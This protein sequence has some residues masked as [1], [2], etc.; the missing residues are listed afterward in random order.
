MTSSPFFVSHTLTSLYLEGFAKHYFT[1]VYLV[2]TGIKVTFSPEIS[3]IALM[4]SVKLPLAVALASYITKGN[5]NNSPDPLGPTLTV[6]ERHP[7]SLLVAT[8]QKFVLLIENRSVLS[9]SASWN[10]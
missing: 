6:M 10:H 2:I 5:L 3:S 7:L 9:N 1:T 8:S 4:V